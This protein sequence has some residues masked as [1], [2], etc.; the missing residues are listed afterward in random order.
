MQGI[1]VRRPVPGKVVPQD[2][3]PVQRNAAEPF[4]SRPVLLA[5]AVTEHGDVL[6]MVQEEL[7]YR[8]DAIEVLVISSDICPVEKVFPEVRILD[9]VRPKIR[10]LAVKCSMCCAL[11]GALDISKLNEE[12][13]NANE[14]QQQTTDGDVNL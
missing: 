4:E 10:S 12:Q 6:E 9:E 13:R 11:H 8:D 2:R 7:G 1:R 3:T 5:K 14:G